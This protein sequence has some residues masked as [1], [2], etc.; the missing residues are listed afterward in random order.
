MNWVNYVIISS[1]LL[2][3]VEYLFW[4]WDNILE[5]IWCELQYVVP[6]PILCKMKRNWDTEFTCISQLR[7]WI[8][9]WKEVREYLRLGQWNRRFFRS[10]FYLWETLNS[11]WRSTSRLHDPMSLAFRISVRDCLKFHLSFPHF[12]LNLSKRRRYQSLPY[13]SNQL[14]SAS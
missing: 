1:S 9:N 3:Q 8:L 4:N 13:D 7:K 2:V 5:F 12:W 14:Y 6:I 11:L 10:S